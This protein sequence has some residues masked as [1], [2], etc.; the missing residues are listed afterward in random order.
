MPDDLKVLESVLKKQDRS[1]F[2]KYRA[3]V[4][5]N[6]DPERRGRLRLTVPSVLGGEQSDWA[7]PCFPY[8]GGPDFGFIA[9][10]PVDSQVVAE[11][12]EGD[13][14]SP[15]WTGTFWRR[16]DEVPA[17]LDGDAAP[18]TKLMKTESG[19]YLSFEDKDGAETITLKSAADAIVEMD[20]DGSIALT[21]SDGGTVVLDAAAG[22]LTVEDANGNSLVMS[23][24][25]IE[26]S[27]G[28]GNSITTSAGGVEVSATTIKI[29]GSQVTVGTGAA[30][31]LIKGQSFMALFNAHTHNCTAPGAPSGPPLAPL[32]PAM[33]T[34]AT[35]GA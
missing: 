32:T 3:F 5:D 13:V 17:E 35:K 31:P 1:Y 28:N 23:S 10:P 22:T 30:E 33:M 2:G 25:G 11:F 9:V 14:S 6:A 27:D 4:A 18:T 24:S 8:G 20:H 7:L 12:I 21:G 34:V 26:A 19:H 16:S 29:S 15:I